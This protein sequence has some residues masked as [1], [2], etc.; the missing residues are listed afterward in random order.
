MGGELVML[1]PL[2]GGIVDRRQSIDVS[3]AA[4]QRHA[5]RTEYTIEPKKN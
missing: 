4:T 2:N 3:G 5:R 1:R